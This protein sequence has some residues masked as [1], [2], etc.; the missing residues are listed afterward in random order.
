MP[1]ITPGSKVL[2]TG[3]TGFIGIWVTRTLLEKGYSVRGTVRSE[4][5]GKYVLDYFKSYGEK[6]ET[7]IVEDISK[8]GAF[9]EAVEDVDAI[10]HVASPFHFK[11]DDPQDIIGPAVNGTLGVLKSA[12]RNNPTLKRVVITSSCAT[13]LETLPEPKVFSELDWNEQCL[14][15][16]EEKGKAASNGAKYQASK[17]L[18]ERAAWEFYEKHKSEISWDVVV[19]NPPYVFGPVIHE[20]PSR[21]SL[22][23]SSSDL[24]DALIAP[25]TSA[26]AMSTETLTT[27]GSCWID[28]R[29]LAEAHTKA[30]ETPDAGGERI[31]TSAGAYIWQ[32]L[33]DVAQGL[34]PPAVLPP[35][36]KLAVGV[37]GGGK[38]AIPKIDYDTAKAARILGMKYRSREDT[39]RAS[40]EKV[41]NRGW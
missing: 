3:A 24:L 8:E 37:P 14:K 20:V 9:D 11:A 21:G 38:G 39:I 15:Q 17:T 12:L 10:A 5:K 7:V 25:S 30:L 19:L 40:I 33:I 32:D 34:S 41:L 26:S 36:Y 2:V 35:Q 13:V 31:I 16:V 6:F 29:D 1:T 28:V 18:A 23:Q 4:R 22:N 27:D